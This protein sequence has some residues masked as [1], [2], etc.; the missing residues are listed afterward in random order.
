MS[1]LW[2]TVVA[3]FAFSLLS[4]AQRIV[5][6]EQRAFPDSIPAGGYSGIAW[7]GGDR[8]A[9]VSDN[10]ND[11]FFI[12]RISIDSI[13][14]VTSASHLGFRG[15]SLPGHDNEGIA[16]MASDST[17]FVSGER[18]NQVREFS[19]S[20]L[21]TGRR[22]PLPEAFSR[23]TRSYGLEALTYNA[24]AHR[25]WT[26]SESTLSGDGLK[27]SPDNGAV[28]RLRLQSFDDSLHAC[29]QY[30]YMMDEP[31]AQT[32]PQHYAFG[33]SALTAL[34]DGRLLVLERE[35]AVPESKIG[36][37]VSCRIYMVD[38]AE[39][40]PVAADADI[41]QVPSVR[42]MLMAEWMTA[43]GLLDVSIANY[44]GMCLGPRLADGGQVIVLIA[45]S[46]NQYAGVL[47]DWIKTLVIYF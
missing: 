16:W 37:F 7:L 30:V 2:M 28:N 40:K 20:G 47:S 8:Y 31:M 26:T 39:E 17:L 42:K 25:F 23:A 34:D 10:G 18:D 19:F 13:G 4:V 46:Q 29:E 3:A 27:S 43:I 5:E 15:T 1:R 45:D 21:P 41:T 9:V 24:A 35:F 14:A 22:L 38:P 11:G 32:M 6:H 44:E 12:F 36:A 33:V